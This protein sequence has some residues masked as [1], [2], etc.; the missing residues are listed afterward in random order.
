MI[1]GH[2]EAGELKMYVQFHSRM[3]C[4]DHIEVMKAGELKTYG[5]ASFTRRKH[6]NIYVDEI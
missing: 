6:E 1:R 4:H 2:Q 3:L 5:Q